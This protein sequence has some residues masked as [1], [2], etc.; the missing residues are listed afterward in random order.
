M[1]RECRHLNLGMRWSTCSTEFPSGPTIPDTEGG[2]SGCRPLH[3]QFQKSFSQ[4]TSSGQRSPPTWTNK[5]QWFRRHARIHMLTHWETLL[6]ELAAS[7]CRLFVKRLDMLR[8][9]IDLHGKL[10]QAF[11]AWLGQACRQT[12]SSQRG[13]NNRPERCGLP[14][15]LWVNRLLLPSSLAPKKQRYRPRFRTPVH[16]TFGQAKDA[17]RFDE[18][19]M[20]TSWNA[21]LSRNWNSPPCTHRQHEGANEGGIDQVD[22]KF[23]EKMPLICFFLS[24]MLM[25]GEWAATVA[26]PKKVA[27][28]LVASCCEIFGLL[29]FLDNIMQHHK[30]FLSPPGF[31]QLI[32][33]PRCDIPCMGTQEPC[34][35]HLKRRTEL[36]REATVMYR[37]KYWSLVKTLPLGVSLEYVQ[38]MVIPS[39]IQVEYRYVYIIYIYI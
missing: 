20:P 10:A 34:Q 4:T 6:Q 35:L 13:E 28:F 25:Q 22:L 29:N 33:R 14:A 23:V 21:C 5:C 36:M 31:F 32:W 1:Q 11:S 16:Y 18:F 30:R 24:A 12:C 19:N 37:C 8:R 26:V 15:M 3:S 38:T 27:L 7:T 2:C 17:L 9:Q 39:R